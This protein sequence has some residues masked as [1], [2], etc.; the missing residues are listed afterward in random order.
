MTLPAQPPRSVSNH[1]EYQ[2]EFLSLMLFPIPTGEDR[3]ANANANAA[4]RSN[5]HTE[6]SATSFGTT[7]TITMA[8]AAAPTFCSRSLGCSNKPHLIKKSTSRP[9]NPLSAYNL[10][11][12]VERRRILDGNDGLGRTP[13]TAPEI[14][15][16]SISNKK[17]QQQGTKRLHRK[18]HGKISF[19][20]LA[21]TIANR[22][23]VLDD[24]TRRLLEQQALLEKQEHVQLVEIWE[25]EEQQNL[26]TSF[27]DSSVAVEGEQELL[28]LQEQHND[29]FLLPTAPSSSASPLFLMNVRNQTHVSSSPVSSVTSTTIFSPPSSYSPHPVH[30]HGVSPSSNHQVHSHDVCSPSQLSLASLSRSRSSESTS[31]MTSPVLNY[32]HYPT[33]HTHPSRMEEHLAHLLGRLPP[34]FL[35]S[36]PASTT[37]ASPAVSASLVAAVE[38]CHGGG[39][40]TSSPPPRMSNSNSKD[41]DDYSITGDEEALENHHHQDAGEQE[42]RCHALFSLDEHQ[43]QQSYQEKEQ[44][45]EE[46]A[47]PPPSSSPPANKKESSWPL[48]LC[49]FL[50]STGGFTSLATGF[51]PM[52]MTTTIT[53]N[54]MTG[55]NSNKNGGTHTTTSSTSKGAV[56]AVESSI[57]HDSTV[58]TWHHHQPSAIR[59]R[60]IRL[61]GT[62]DSHDPA[63]TTVTAAATRTVT[64]SAVDLFALIDPDEMD[65][66]FNEDEDE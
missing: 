53:T 37:T 44:T 12:Q 59:S 21:G 39:S 25:Q 60:S 24:E 41:E 19:G 58:M 61:V 64:V 45:G 27:R 56:G 18:S 1:G 62:S 3:A 46:S 26:E 40:S 63:A 29:G 36:Q 54:T 55:A 38:T 23:K 57:P 43:Q 10:Y 7:S 5:S 28:R 9:K 48:S 34:P 50:S 22:W 52:M 8:T 32:N 42:R 13:I 47:P 17:L 31:E 20:E 65:A 14:L 11:F 51:A 30:P 16:A 15:E 2:Q 4:G 6:A 33:N 35:S 66:I 49:D